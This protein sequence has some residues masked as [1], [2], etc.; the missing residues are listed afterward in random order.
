[1]KDEQIEP[2]GHSGFILDRAGFVVMAFFF[3]VFVNTGTGWAIEQKFSTLDDIMTGFED[4]DSEVDVGETDWESG[5]DT[6]PA[7]QGSDET[8]VK[9]PSWY[10][11][12][13]ALQL[14]ASFNTAHDRPDKGQADYRG[15]SRYRPKLDLELELPLPLEWKL[16]ASGQG[17]YDFAYA[18]KGRSQFTENVLEAHEYEAELTDTYVQGRLRSRLDLKL[19]RQIVVWGKSDNLRVTDVLNPLDNREP[20]L[21]DIEDLRLPVAMARIDY[22]WGASDNWNITALV[23]PELRFGKDPV[24]GSDFFP[25]EE[26]PLSAFFNQAIEKKP[27]S[28][29]ANYEYALAV[30]GIFSG[31]DLSFYGARF[32][33]D[34]YH[35]FLDLSGGM[36]G[37]L[38]E[39]RHNDL[40][41]AGGAVNVAFGNLLL[42]AELAWLTGFEYYSIND[43]KS[44]FDFLLGLEYTG[45]KDTTVSLEAVNRHLFAFEVSM[46]DSPNYGQE[47]SF[48]GAL[49]VSR[50]LFH[51]TLEITMVASMLGERGQE[52][53]FERFSAKYDV[54]DALEMSGGII[55]YHHGD[56][57]FFKNIEDKDRLFLEFKYSF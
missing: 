33:E 50:S 44:R 24:Y 27:S 6:D 53:A 34:Q 3:I 55:L 41:M 57:V 54:A 42:K 51:E 15:L 5:F 19:G 20:G 26:G 43:K 21:V 25:F 38:I 17:F 23:I 47:D 37:L 31:W 39:L 2:K 14:A 49:R 52:G 10:H 4:S 56:N 40:Y 12:S 11:L 46:G 18:M 48:Q 32:F 9:G 29:P 8:A 35:P 1:M 28:I 30:N 7:V 45:L 22:Y 36:A 13:G 16:I